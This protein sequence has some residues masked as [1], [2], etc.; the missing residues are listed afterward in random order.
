M[1][2]GI[3]SWM[4]ETVKFLL[5]SCVCSPSWKRLLAQLVRLVMLAFGL[6]IYAGQSA[7]RMHNII[8]IF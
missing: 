5:P 6:G 1:V 2:Q 8:N 7:E 3:T 4:T